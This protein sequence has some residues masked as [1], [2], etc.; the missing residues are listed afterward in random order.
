MEVREEAQSAQRRAESNL[1]EMRRD[2][3]N[4]SQMITRAM[5]KER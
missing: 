5:Y 3:S 2:Q 4:W 1:I